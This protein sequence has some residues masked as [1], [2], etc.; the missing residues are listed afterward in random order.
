MQGCNR[1]SMLLRGGLLTILLAAVA[2]QTCSPETPNNPNPPPNFS[3]ATACG[4]LATEC[5]PLTGAFPM[6]LAAGDLDG[7]GSADLAVVNWGTDNVS[8]LL[9]K[10]DASFADMGNLQV[11][12]SPISAVLGDWDGDGRLDLASTGGL[13][14]W[15]YH[16]KGNA[17]FSELPIIPM[18]SPSSAIVTADFDGDGFADLAAA[19]GFG[20][21][22]YLMYNDGRDG[23]TVSPAISLSSEWIHLTDIVAADL[24]R[25]GLPD[26]AAVNRYSGGISVL[27]NKGAREFADPVDIIISPKH[28]LNAIAAADVNGDGAADLIVADNGNPFETDDP[29]R[30]VLLINNGEGTFA[31]PMFLAAGRSP[32]GIAAADLDGDGDV[33]L[34]VA[35]NMS[36]DLS[37]L[38]N[39]GDGSFDPPETVPAGDG[40]SFVLTADLDADGDPDVAVANASSNTVSI[41]I[42]S[43]HGT[44][45]AGG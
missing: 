13:D 31:D 12:D 21:D 35:N 17:A 3:I 20:H 8:I 33:D 15:L 30:L 44:F 43:G 10:G 6:A 16:N 26:L 22:V 37:V 28:I 29:G 19:N 4:M 7:D 39:R 34:V 11:G 14:L 45:V 40:P 5:V 41:L 25:D 1:Q 9:N 38:R 42:N 27:M 2:G 32:I 24:N 18:D 36:D 23:F